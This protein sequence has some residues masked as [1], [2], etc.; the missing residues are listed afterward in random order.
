MKIA[1]ISK[2]CYADTDF[3][4]IR[5]FQ[6]MGH[7][8]HYFLNVDCREL[9]STLIDISV[10]N[11]DSSLLPPTVYKEL[12]IYRG[13]LDMSH[14][15]IVNRAEKS[16]LNYK[17]IY[18][19]RLIDK[20]MQEIKPDVV[21][22]LEPFYIND[23]LLYKWRKKM[24][25]TM[26][27]PF[28]HSGESFGRRT[29]FRNVAFKMITKYVLL[30][31]R[32]KGKFMQV[33]GKQA[34]DILTNCIGQFDYLK[35]FIQNVKSKT[36][37]NVLFFGRISPYKGIEY[38][39]EAMTLVRQKIP[40]A[41]LTIAGGG[42]FYFDKTRYSSQKWIKIINQYIT[43]KEMSELFNDCD[44]SVCPYIDA[45]Q[46]GVIN[47]SYSLSKPVVATNVGGLPEMVVDGKTGILV[48]PKNSQ[49]LAEAIVEL[50]KDEKKLEMMQ[51][52]IENVYYASSKS[53]QEIANKYIAF[54]KTI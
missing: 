4:L 12:D 23:L 48:P 42:Q 36:R 17:T 3:P 53:W 15:Y 5:Q 43:I 14:V 11:P 27:D 51:E 47:T 13:Y 46:S 35:L 40:D 22:I 30:N 18:L 21:H 24:V 20:K 49:I 50:L 32:Q 9:H 7:E 34:N 38:L 19:S 54:Y 2:S 8:V 1:Y 37:H 31:E 29:F 45:T 26:H 41:T 16:S 44:I 52:Y 6:Q 10:Q 25:L 28:P 33:Y 39:C